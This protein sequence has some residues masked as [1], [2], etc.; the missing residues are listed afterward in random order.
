MYVSAWSHTIHVSRIDIPPWSF[1][2]VVRTFLCCARTVSVLPTRRPHVGRIMAP[3]GCGYH[4]GHVGVSLVQA[5][6]RERFLLCHNVVPANVHDGLPVRVVEDV[7][8]RRV[9]AA[10]RGGT[11]LDPHRPSGT[12]P[13]RCL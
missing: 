1:C 6:L 13:F 3:S 11:S 4:Q 9:L 5:A 8:A 10:A 12:W 2:R 7:I